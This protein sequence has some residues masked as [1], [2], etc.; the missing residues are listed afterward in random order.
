M[1]RI[2]NNSPPPRT[3][4]TAPPDCQPGFFILFGI[5]LNGADFLERQSRLKASLSMLV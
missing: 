2:T 1:T 5:V 4:L 3:R